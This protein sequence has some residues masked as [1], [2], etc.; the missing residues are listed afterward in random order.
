M[1]SALRA[2]QA[3]LGALLTDPDGQH[4]VLTFVQPDD[5][6]RAWHGQVLAAMQRLRARGVLAGPGQVYAELRHDP[7]LP[8]SVSHDALPLADLMAATPRSANAP[9]YAGIVIRAS[10]RR[11]LGVCGGRLRQAADL[12]GRSMTETL[13]PHP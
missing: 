13:A 11:R 5:F 8:R 10:I 3:L 9:S 1:N 6:Y 2:E 4:Q 7:D 12:S